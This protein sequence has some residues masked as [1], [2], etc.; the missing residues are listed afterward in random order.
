ME[1][2]ERKRIR[3]LL[4]GGPVYAAANSVGLLDILDADD[5]LAIS[6]RDF[7][8]TVGAIDGYTRELK[9]LLSSSHPLSQSIDP[10]D[11]LLRRNIIQKWAE[12]II[13]SHGIDDSSEEYQDKILAYARVI[14]AVTTGRDRAFILNELAE[15]TESQLPLAEKLEKLAHPEVNSTIARVSGALKDRG[16]IGAV[17]INSLFKFLSSPLSREGIEE[18]MQNNPD[19]LIDRSSGVITPIISLEDFYNDFWALTAEKRE[20]FMNI[21]LNVGQPPINFK[22]QMAAQGSGLLETFLP[23]EEVVKEGRI[24][25]KV[26]GQ[27]LAKS[28]GMAT[29]NQELAHLFCGMLHAVHEDVVRPRA[30]NPGVRFGY[31]LNSF[32]VYIGG[33]KIAQE[34]H[35]FGNTREEWRP[36]LADSKHLVE[37]ME[38]AAFLRRVANLPEGRASTIKRIGKRLGTGTYADTKEIEYT[39][40]FLA[41][42]TDEA[43]QQNGDGLVL[44]LVKEN[45]GVR[46]K[47][48]FDVTIRTV[49]QMIECDAKAKE[50]VEGLLPVFEVKSALIAEETD[51]DIAARK[52]GIVETLLKG[53]GVHLKRDD[54]R[55]SV[56]FTS[57]GAFDHGK[58][59]RVSSHMR[60]VHFN[61]LPER[62]Y[63][64]RQAKQLAAESIFAVQLF[65]ILSGRHFDRDRHGRNQGIRVGYDANNN[66]IITVGD[67]D[68][69]AVT[70]D[71]PTE[72][73]KRIFANIVMDA[74]ANSAINGFNPV[75]SL[76]HTF[77]K[78]Q[79]SAE[80]S[81]AEHAEDLRYVDSTVEAIVSLGDVMK[82]VGVA[83]Y[84][85][86][87]KAVVNTGQIDPVIED[88]FKE[89]F[90]S[91]QKLLKSPNSTDATVAK[92][93]GRRE[94]FYPPPT[95]ENRRF[96]NGF[97]RFVGKT[98]L[99]LGAKILGSK[100]LGL[101]GGLVGSDR[102]VFPKSY[103]DRFRAGEA[104]APSV[105]ER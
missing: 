3:N 78:A 97:N 61:D 5:P 45:S 28:V 52:A 65:T 94:E 84:V 67:F 83:G 12:S 74:L 93:R 92:E 8:M 49:K 36:G 16:T 69:G 32:L 30:E 87:I 48:I 80:L 73:Q 43:A 59:F 18:L 63:G 42:H 20:E 99:A 98:V 86:A 64:E 56:R 25:P 21:V 41:D 26:L 53:V 104:T 71:P 27:T 91:I 88:T 37:P 35:S 101:V 62:T 85:R 58:D 55:H 79:K 39:D 33:A 100:V 46:S 102:I 40:E 11:V 57:A 31:R 54:I 15:I 19:F 81:G 47:H 51:M 90:A 60:G 23:P 14:S 38:R 105:A 44:Q 4:G 89:R 96:T 6:P 10:R 24:A 7:A 95:D 2:V 34:L 29:T 50:S 13:N 22:M 70:L 9:S 66:L 1:E 76:K 72:N 82:H 68:D 103:A 17:S 77:A 75:S